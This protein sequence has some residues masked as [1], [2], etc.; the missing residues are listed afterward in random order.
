MASPSNEKDNEIFTEFSD[1]IKKYYSLSKKRDQLD[2]F[3]KSALSRKDS[4]KP[5]IFS[6]VIDDY[7]EQ[8]SGTVQQWRSLGEDLIKDLNTFQSNCAEYEMQIETL[9]D[10]LEELKFRVLVGEYQPEKVSARER[11][12]EGKIAEIKMK[13]GV[14][15]RKVNYYMKIQQDIQSYRDDEIEIKPDENDFAEREVSQEVEEAVSSREASPVEEMP[16][17]VMEEFIA[18]EPQEDVAGADV[19]IKSDEMEEPPVE[20]EEEGDV[21]NLDDIDFESKEEEII[22]EVNA[23]GAGLKEED[24]GE[25][26]E[27]IDIGPEEDISFENFEWDESDLDISKDLLEEDGQVDVDLGETDIA[28]DESLGSLKD[29]EGPQAEAEG[30]KEVELGDGDEPGLEEELEFEIIEEFDDD[31]LLA[32][33]D[34]KGE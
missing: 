9:D 2:Q 12:L 7:K 32:A 10:E 8:R 6:K 14:V 19:E 1:E 13:H 5:K 17:P 22:P 31:E 27:K 30:M 24:V 29:G 26:V 16:E 3:I 4:V 28:V 34:V 21:F 33:S 25:P 20:M 15:V 23:S 11:E 18:E